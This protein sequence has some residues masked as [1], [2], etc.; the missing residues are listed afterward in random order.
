MIAL[1][2]CSASWSR[3]HVSAAFLPAALESRD[4]AALKT[5]IFHTFRPFDYLVGEAGE[6]RG[7]VMVIGCLDES[8]DGLGSFCGQGVSLVI[9]WLVVRWFLTCF[10]RWR[11]RL[12]EEFHR[13]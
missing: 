1:S 7:G 4:K 12:S 5:P 6:E 13:R 9:L 3:R 10:L 11:L 8:G 2:F